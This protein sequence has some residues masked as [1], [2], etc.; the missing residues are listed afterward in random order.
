MEI[1]LQFSLAIDFALLV[2]IL[3]VQ[4]IIYPTF[5][6]IHE[7]RFPSWHDSYCRLIGFIVSPLMSLQLVDSAIMIYR[8]LHLMTVLKFLIV[9]LTWFLTFYVFVPLHKQLRLGWNFHLIYKLVQCNW[10]RTLTWG[11]VFVI[12]FIIEFSDLVFL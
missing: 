5:L 6:V 12:S 8:N 4:L 9:I 1:L 7:E 11:L 10:L 3:L 2:L